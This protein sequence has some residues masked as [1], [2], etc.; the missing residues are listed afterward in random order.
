MGAGTPQPSA[1]QPANPQPLAP[2]SPQAMGLGALQ[3]AYSQFQ[4]TPA[5]QPN[6]MFGAQP[7]AQAASN[8]L[9]SFMGTQAAPPAAPAAPPPMP[10]AQPQAPLYAPQQVRPEDP[11]MQAMR[12]LQRTGDMGHNPYVRNY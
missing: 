11:R 6:P 7:Q 4:N 12:G 8:V 10:A 2:M 9:D 3:N 5:P 1:G